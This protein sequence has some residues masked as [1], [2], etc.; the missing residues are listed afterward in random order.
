MSN[1]WSNKS[2]AWFATAILATLV[3]VSIGLEVRGDLIVPGLPGRKR[4][5]PRPE[6]PAAEVAPEAATGIRAPVRILHGRANLPQQVECRIMLP[7]RALENLLKRGDGGYIAPVD[8]IG[9]DEPRGGTP[10]WGTVIAAVLLAGSIA[11]LPFAWLRRQTSPK[12]GWAVGAAVVGTIAALL[13]GFYLT[14]GSGSLARADIAVPGARNQLIQLE[15]T[16]AGDRVTLFL[17]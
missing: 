2:R 8:V 13:T 10:V 4:P 17:K 9:E 16:D 6:P 12:R 7:R 1:S 5:L 15:V 11:I 3:V 14:S